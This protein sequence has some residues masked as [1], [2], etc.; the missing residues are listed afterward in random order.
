M[1]II[2]L[3][4]DEGAARQSSRLILEQ[5]DH[6]VTE[7]STVT[8]AHS[9]L[10]TSPFDLV[11]CDID[12]SDESGMGL[13]RYV[14]WELPDTAMIMVTSVDDPAAAD[15]AIAMGTYG[16]LVKPFRPNEMLISVTEIPH[17]KWTRWLCG[18]GRLIE[19]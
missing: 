7:A 17:S 10:A 4:D 8:K 12:M 2:L 1:A 15:E 3:V 18:D 19:R 14:A 16:Y 5:Q 11:L 13:V 6:F 9:L